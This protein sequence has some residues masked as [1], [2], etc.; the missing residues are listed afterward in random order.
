MIDLERLNKSEIRKNFLIF[1]ILM[2]KTTTKNN[3]LG[4]ASPAPLF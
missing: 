3:M 2:T 4:S 1:K